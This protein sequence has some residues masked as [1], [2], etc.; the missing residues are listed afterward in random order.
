M[1]R[2]YKVAAAAAAVELQAASGPLVGI[3]VLL[4]TRLAS[5]SVRHI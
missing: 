4:A 1:G 2:V 5:L 3:M